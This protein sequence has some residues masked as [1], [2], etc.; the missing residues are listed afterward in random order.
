MPI[1]R[2]K[3]PSV[4]V[5]HFT[6]LFIKHP[7][8]CIPSVSTKFCGFHPRRPAVG[9]QSVTASYQKD[10]EP[11]WPPSRSFSHLRSMSWLSSHRRA[12]KPCIA[13]CA[14]SMSV[15]GVIHVSRPSIN[16]GKSL[17]S[18]C[19]SSSVRKSLLFEQQALISCWI[20]S[21]A[22]TLPPFISSTSLSYPKAKRY[23]GI[24]THRF[25]WCVNWCW[26]GRR[27]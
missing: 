11:T 5:I 16:W 9:Y 15:R 7:S 13:T 1:N 17:M 26:I 23:F 3:R 22:S 27:V 2:G 10:R 8:L 25:E 18:N 21:A 14:V 6:Q 24:M 19:K 4:C 12:S 20:S